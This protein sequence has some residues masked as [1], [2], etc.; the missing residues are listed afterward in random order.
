MTVDGRV[1]DA[2]TSIFSGPLR[3][4]SA[5]LLILITLIAFEAM[6]VSAALPTAVRDVHGISSYGWAFT[7]FLAANIVAM[8]VS[9]QVSDRRG[10]R[11]P[12]IAGLV[13]FV[14][15]LLLS[16]TASTMWQ[17]VAG[18]VVQGAGGGLMVTA[19][20]VVIGA[21]YPERLRPPVFAATASAWVVPS[22]VGPTMAGLLAQHASWR[23]VF[24][25]LVPFTVIGGVL[26]TPVL[27]SLRAPTRSAGLAR[28]DR[29]VRAVAVAAGI[30]AL[31]HA[32]QD[33]S[34]TTLVVGAV[35]LVVLGW[36]LCRLV[37]PGTFRVRPGVAAPV[38]MRGLLAGAFFGIE[39]TLPLALSIQ[40]GYDATAAALPLTVAGFSWAAGS[41]WQGRAD[42]SRGP[43]VRAAL[44]R[45]GFVFMFAAALVMSV[46]VLPAPTG[47]LAFPS[48]VLA[49]LGAG[50][51]MSSVS[52]LLLNFTTDSERGADSAALQLSDATASAITTGLAG[53]LVA[54]AAR[55]TIGFTA[56]FV[57]LDLAM[58]AVAG[59]GIAVSGRARPA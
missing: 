4:T 51:T 5:G 44:I 6:A 25:G 31:E 40:H 30:V 42:D 59:V 50:L 16:G 24:L 38:A 41:W 20:Y 43:Q 57:I 9:G 35:G 17:L 37:P 19:V 39:A 54:A 7:G 8:V 10:P 53:V 48:W 18:R 12:L 29:L 55:A 15:G 49:G 36:G 26:M 1:E 28:Q 34:A 27:R 47:W 21:A 56:A 45:T 32:G 23:W 11:G 33:P 3:R 46:A 13:F 2:P 52:V 22:L 14:A 58:A